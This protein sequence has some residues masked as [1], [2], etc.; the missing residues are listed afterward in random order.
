MFKNTLNIIS[1]FEKLPRL[2]LGL[3]SL[4]LIMLLSINMAAQKKGRK[5]E[6]KGADDLIYDNSSGES[7]K[8]LIGN[9]KLK[10]GRTFLDCDSAFVYTESNTMNAY[11]NV[12]LYGKDEIEMFGDSAKYFGA[13]KIA[14]IRGKEVKLIQDGMVLTTQ[15]LDYNRGTKTG[16]YWNG[17]NILMNDNKD[18]L[19]S[20]LGKYNRSGEMEFKDSVRLRTSEYKISS[21]TLIY[22]SNTKISKFYGPTYIESD[23]DL[24]YTERGWSDS[25]NKVSV[26]TTHAYIFTKDQML[27]GDSIFYDQ[28][29]NIGE[30][31]Y[32]V[33]MIDT[34]NQFMIEG[35]YVYLNQ[36]DSTSLVLGEPMLTQ[37]FE[38]DSLYLHADTL[39]SY[40]D[41]SRTNRLIHAYPQGQFYKSDMQ[42]KSDSIVFSDVDSTI[43]LYHNPVIWSEENQ[44]TAQTITIYKTGDVIDRMTMDYRAFIISLEDSTGKYP[45]YNQIKG[46]S[47]VGHFEEN[48]LKK[49]DV[50][51]NGKTIYFAKEEDGPY[52]GMNKA[53]SEF[54][55]IT[56]DSNQVSEILFKVLP[57]ATL[58]PIDDVT[59][60][61][62]YL[63]RFV[64]REN[65][66][67]FKKEEIF[68]WKEEEE[69]TKGE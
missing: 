26:F 12:H 14:Q 66:R 30:V 47:M 67:P 11:G 40:Y 23:S 29:N 46:D 25:K 27:Y 6:I 7:A 38:N 31:F 43:T 59:P 36:K 34:T 13:T 21:D 15:F 62:Q 9:V 37:F 19:F 5:I 33:K 49:V 10:F 65:E 50:N 51:H 18:S 20:Y 54:M 16:N 48:K 41:T 52:I 63:K 45:K 35:E 60:R 58:Y 68:L 3:F 44:I 56:L 39:Y 28:Q 55:V 24:I 32:N 2:T 53:E 64:W 69:K 42:G 8:K 61:M 17:A 22:N 4:L 1:S 57:S